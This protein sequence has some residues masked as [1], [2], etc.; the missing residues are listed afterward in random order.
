MISVDY[1]YDFVTGRMRREATDTL[2]LKMLHGW[3]G[4]AA[5]A[6]IFL[7]KID[8]LADA[9]LGRFWEIQAMEITLWTTPIRNLQG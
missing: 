7:M 6:R 8:E 9:S 2:A 3:V 4:P 1:C 5:E